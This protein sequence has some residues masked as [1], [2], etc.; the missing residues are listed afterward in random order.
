[1]L[2][3]DAWNHQVALALLAFLVVAMLGM[4]G[5]AVRRA[6]GRSGAKRRRR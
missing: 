3:P 2:R 1:V 6:L 5:V 4:F